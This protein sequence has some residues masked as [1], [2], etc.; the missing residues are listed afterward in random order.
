MVLIVTALGVYMGLS[1][2]EW[3]VITIVIGGVLCAELF[4]TAIEY[5]CDRITTDQDAQIGRVKDVSAAAVL[6]AAITASLVG[7]WIFLPRLY[8]LLLSS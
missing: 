7:L 3:T 5:L 1:L 2:V 4:N 8:A 6:I